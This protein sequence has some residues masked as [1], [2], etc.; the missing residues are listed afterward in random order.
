M[1]RGFLHD[2]EDDATTNNMMTDKEEGP[3]WSDD[4]VTTAKKGFSFTSASSRNSDIDEYGN[5]MAL[6]GF[7][8]FIC[9]EKNWC[10]VYHVVCS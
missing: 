5:G 1:R 8:C 7:G 9:G 2:A 6:I 4:Q 3:R 10:C